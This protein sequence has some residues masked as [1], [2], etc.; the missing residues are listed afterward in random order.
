[1]THR[2]LRHLIPLLLGSLLLAVPIGAGE[3]SPATAADAI[4]TLKASGKAVPG[5][6]RAAASAEYRARLRESG[7][8]HLAAL[9]DGGSDNTN[10]TLITS[11]PYL[12]SGN[13][14]GKGNN[15][16]LP[17]CLSGGS[18]TAEDAW[19]QLDLAFDSEVTVWTTCQ[20]VG[21]PSYDTRIAIFDAS[22]ALITC[23]DDAPNC[24]SPNYQS[25][26]SDTLLPAGTY[27]VVVDGYSGNTG[28]YEFNATWVVTSGACTGGSDSSNPEAVT[29]IPF[30]GA[31]TTADACHNYTLDCEL[32][33]GGG[34]PDYWYLVSLDTTVFFEVWTTCDT[35]DIDTRI[36]VVDTNLNQV[37]CNDDDTACASGQSSITRA[38]LYPGDYY[39]I[40]EGADTT[41][42]TYEIHMDTTVVPPDS[43]TALL[44][45]IVVRESDLYDHDISTAIQPGRT[46]LRLSNGT[47]NAGDGK[48][49]IYGSGVDNGDGSENILQRV[50]L[51]GG[52][53][54]DRTAGA[55]I[56]HESHNHIHVE[57]WSIYRL[58]EALPGDGVGAEVAKGVKTSFCILDLAIYDNTLPNHDPSGQFFNCSSTIQGLSVGW[59]DI[60]SK[61][62]AGQNIDITDVPDG[63]Y[64]LESEVDP[65][66]W[67]LESDESNNTTR[68]KVTLGGGPAINPDPYEP[69]DG[70]TA[71]DARPAGGNNSP[72]LGPANPQTTL[73]GLTLHVAGNDDLF[74]F[75]ANHSGGPADFVR[76][77]FDSTEGNLDLALLDSTGTAV[78]S[79]ATTTLGTETITLDGR[80]E[81][82]YYARV[83]SPSSD[84]ITAYA[85]TVDPPSNTPPQLT[86]GEPATGTQYIVHGADAFIVTWS[87]A[88]A[89]NDETW[90]TVYYNT[91]PVLDGNETLLPTSL[92]SPG[93]QGFH[94][95][96]SAY[97]GFDTY[98]FYFEITDG[99]TTT[100]AWSQGNLTVLDAVTGADAPAAVTRLHPAYP[101]PFNPATT[102]RLDLAERSAVSWRI[103][104]VRGNL[105]KVVEEG[106]LN[107]GPHERRWDGTDQS[108]RPVASG[109]YFQK[110]AATGF[111][112]TGKLVLLK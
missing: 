10:A 38:F 105:V 82:W 57:D 106:R 59:V 41:S 8:S 58:R 102:L 85:L 39:V 12:D 75:Y 60:Y 72:N 44:P 15:A 108:G 46:H 9:L 29:A 96:N 101:N 23:N 5:Q 54:F 40:V 55:F 16:L 35:L 34:A 107:A 26:I 43:N 87:A 80:P 104:D 93:A 11:N 97:L 17:S 83:F 42:G 73:T 7:E 81:G 74:R 91:T 18:D 37:Y 78:D 30:S 53:W 13:T 67:F 64:W 3:K 21:P 112:Q 100:G 52:T 77:A 111:V 70:T 103:Y 20:T 88:D 69:N 86:P 19:Y 95:V 109:I 63:T 51:D 92:H 99:G 94:V 22:L 49:Y 31:G 33:A 90:V 68:I 84:L 28:P 27:Y 48:L 110:V 66:D 36:A 2:R 79:S 98:W 56:F 62:L 50:Y 14:A 1:M 45:D 71:V 47:A 89:E 76:V 32:G 4:R 65:F 6:L 24:G 25:K 61:N